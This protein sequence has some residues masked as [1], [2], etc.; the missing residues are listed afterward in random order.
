MEDNYTYDPADKKIFVRHGVPCESHPDHHV[1]RVGQVGAHGT[2]SIVNPNMHVTLHHDTHGDIVG[3]EVW[4]CE[5]E[6]GP[7]AG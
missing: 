5:E 6:K 7:S 4:C 2:L 1:V 3:V